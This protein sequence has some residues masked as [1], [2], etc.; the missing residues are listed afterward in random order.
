MKKEDRV[1]GLIWLILGIVFCVGAIKLNV[2]N[3]R[4]PGPGFLPLLVGTLLVVLGLILIFY[5]LSSELRE[6]KNG[7]VQK[8]NWRTFLIPL[9]TLFILF[10]YTLLLEYLGFLFTT[11][12]FLFFLFKLGEPKRWL[13]PLIFSVSTVIFSYLIFDVWLQCQ[14]PRG[15]FRF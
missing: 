7:E 13:M 14:L 2:G 12:L 11:F 3:L 1:S 9:L 4:D 5:P 10:G 8:S 6:R 15:I